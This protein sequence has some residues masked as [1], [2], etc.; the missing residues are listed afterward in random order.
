[1]NHGFI[2]V[3][4]AVPELRV[5]DCQ[6]NSSKIFE[7]IEQAEQESTE[8]VF[9]RTI[10]AR[11]STLPKRAFAKIIFLSCSFYCR[12]AFTRKQPLI[13]CGCSSTIR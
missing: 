6:F 9:S 12:N 2:R 7:L 3:A 5:A 4:T 11:C 8:F 1:M 10:T 13:Q